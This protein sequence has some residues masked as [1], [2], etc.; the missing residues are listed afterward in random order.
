MNHT[1][2]VCFPSLAASGYQLTSPRTRVYNCIA[3]AA[4]DQSNWWWPDAMGNYFWP[5]VTRSETVAAFIEAYSTVGYSPC[6]NGDLEA[7]IEKIVIF[8]LNGSPT[9]AARQL[10][11][12]KWTSKCGNLEDI[13]HTLL[14]FE[15][16]EYGFPAQFLA[17]SAPHDSIP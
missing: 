3:W 17:R 9:H 6:N 2:E 13:S 7:G 10:P 15:N 1:L 5:N 12:G 11:D 16:S 4:N 8:V 14:A